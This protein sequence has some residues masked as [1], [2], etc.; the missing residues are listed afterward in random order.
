MEIHYETLEQEI[1]GAFGES[2]SMIL[3]TCSGNRVT[4]RAMSCIFKGLNI[5]FQMSTQSTKA[6]QIMEN[7]QVALCFG[8]IQIEGKAII[9]VHPIQA[10]YFKEHYSRLHPGSYKAYSH[11]ESARAVEVQPSSITLWKYDSEGKPY[12]VK[13]DVISRKAVMDYYDTS[14]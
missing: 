5:L 9:L 14:K 13:L 3:A 8:N 7:P 6:R 11:M 12:T 4:A 10:P 2:K 1:L